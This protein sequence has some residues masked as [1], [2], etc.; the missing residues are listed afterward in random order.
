MQRRRTGSSKS[1]TARTVELGRAFV[2]SQLQIQIAV[3]RRRAE[4]SRSTARAIGLPV[5]SSLVWTPPLEES[6]F[7]EYRDGFFL[8]AVG[9]EDLAAS[10]KD[11]WPQRGPRWDGLATIKIDGAANG[12]VLVEAKSY[13]QEMERGGCQAKG[14]SLKKIRHALEDAKRWFG[15]PESADWLGSLYQFANRLAHV[16][17]LRERHGI[18]AWLV[19][20]CIID[21]PTWKATSRAAWTAHMPALRARLGF[22]DRPIPWVREVF[23]PGRSRSE[24]LTDDPVSEI[25]S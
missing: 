17:F 6:C 22:G 19:D 24:L 13:P 12:V 9:L 2:G 23:L 7:A 4:L 10:L 8:R 15:V 5:T 18:R 11:F 21:D 1:P 3:A 25:C 14:A 20:L 16:Y